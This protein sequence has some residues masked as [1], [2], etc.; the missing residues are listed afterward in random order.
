M[1][2]NKL[3][4]LSF[5]IFLSFLS[6]C[7]SFR[8]DQLPPIT[9]WPPELTENKKTISL[10]IAGE[11]LMKGKHQEVNINMLSKWCEHTVKAYQD[12][13]LFSSVSTGIID[14]DIRAEI[15]IIDQGEGSAGL[16]FLSGFTFFIIPAYAY[17]QLSVITT[18]TDKDGNILGQYSK[19]E[20]VT[21]WMHLFLIFVMPFNS[22]F[23]VA[24]E[25]LYD[26]NRATINEAHQ[27]AQF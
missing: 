20:K 2:L 7:A 9:S 19:S 15:R 27:N 6:G 11:A 26:L 16:A 13:G 24:G 21:F 8:A 25:V 17:D 18:L 12:S 10:I 14:S 5:F 22:P 4:L 23:S 1:K 3:R